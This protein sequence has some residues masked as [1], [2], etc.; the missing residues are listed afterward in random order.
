MDH[1][2]GHPGVLLEALKGPPKQP[3]SETT[4][5][6]GPFGSH[7]GSLLHTVCSH[8]FKVI[9]YALWEVIFVNFGAQWAPK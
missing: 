5:L 7:F 6:G 1:I 8:V 4:F 9:S 3:G 2:K